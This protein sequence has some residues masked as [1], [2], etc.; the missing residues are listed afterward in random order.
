MVG[1]ITGSKKKKVLHESDV[2]VLPTYSENFGISVA[3][4]LAHGIPSVVFKGAPWAEL[5]IRNAG[6]W[7]DQNP[8]VLYET[9]EHA[10]QLT[11]ESREDMGRR[12]HAWVKSDFAWSQVAE[13]L[14]K[15]YRWLAGRQSCSPAEIKFVE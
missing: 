14:T 11:D 3:E 2:Y 13:N 4:A 1:E 9:L 10:M 5:D 15:C 7:I 8:G 12:A 6:W